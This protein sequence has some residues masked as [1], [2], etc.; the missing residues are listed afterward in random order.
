M[1]HRK[2]EWYIK[3]ARNY[4]ALPAATAAAAAVARASARCRWLAA[5]PTST[6]DCHTHDLISCAYFGDQSFNFLHHKAS[7]TTAERAESKGKPATCYATLLQQCVAGTPP[8]RPTPCPRTNCLVI[9]VL[10][11]FVTLF[12]KLLHPP[13]SICHTLV[14]KIMLRS[15]L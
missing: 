11:A 12:T 5:T 7:Q 13:R 9:Y 2:I 3:E 6:P 10:F 1:V 14:C 15:G 4:K 8:C